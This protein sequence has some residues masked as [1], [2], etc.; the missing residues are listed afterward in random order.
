MDQVGDDADKETDSHLYTW[1]VVVDNI[2]NVDEAEEDGDEETH[3]ARHHL[4][5][6]DEGGPGHDHEQSGG[7]IVDNQILGVMSRYIHIE[8]GQRQ[9]SELTVVV[10]IQT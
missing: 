10:K 4:G 2:E 8:S 3:P 6:N 1:R 5:G 9:V 7:K